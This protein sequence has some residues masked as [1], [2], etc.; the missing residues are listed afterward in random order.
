MGSALNSKEF[1]DLINNTI[2]EGTM[3]NLKFLP[4][5][6]GATLVITFILYVV[7]HFIFINSALYAGDIRVN[8]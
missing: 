3:R 4:I 1:F 8:S 2:S 5:A 6:L 7:F